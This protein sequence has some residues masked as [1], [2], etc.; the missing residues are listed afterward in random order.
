MTQLS[1]KVAIVT[2]ASSGIGRAAAVLFAKQGASV[3]LTARRED[4]LES[5]AREIRFGGAQAQVVVGDVRDEQI[6]KN[7][8]DSATEHFGGLDIAFNNV[9]W[10]GEMAPCQDV[11]VENFV[12]TLNVNLTSAFIATKYQM[13]AMLNR[14][15][16]SLIYTSSFVGPTMGMPGMMAYAT[17]KAGLSGL[18]HV[19]AVEGGASNVRANAIA[20]GGVDTPMGRTVANTPE[21]IAF[22]E[23]LH[24]LKR[25]AL[26]EEIANA[27]LFLASDASSFMTGAVMPV[28]GGVSKTKV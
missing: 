14:G 12:D 26:P 9:G 27:A 13:P 16:G 15:G 1:G 20:S 11:S 5:V 2:G 25:Q 6:H 28:D 10:L 3:V 23:G 17:A 8:V 24:A 19:A 22:V 21:N 18:V 7:C 4:E